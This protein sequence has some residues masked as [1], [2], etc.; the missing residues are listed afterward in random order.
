MNEGRWKGANHA[1]RKSWIIKSLHGWCFVCHL[2]VNSSNVIANGLFIYKYKRRLFMS[3][4]WSFK[5]VEMMSPW[6]NAK[7]F[8]KMNILKSGYHDHWGACGFVATKMWNVLEPASNP[9]SWNDLKKYNNNNKTTILQLLF[10][11]RR[12]LQFFHPLSLLW[13]ITS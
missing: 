11:K 10:V 5:L 6:S 2:D 4:P 3:Y 12:I 13:I 1:L 7:Q 9:G 8:C